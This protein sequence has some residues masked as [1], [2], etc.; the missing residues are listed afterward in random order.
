MRKKTGEIFLKSPELGAIYRTLTLPWVNQRIAIIRG[1]TMLLDPRYD[2]LKFT[3]LY[4]LYETFQF[5]L[6]NSTQ[7]PDIRGQMTVVL[8]LK[9]SPTGYQYTYLRLQIIEKT[10]V[11][12]GRL[13]QMRFSEIFEDPIEELTWYQVRIGIMRRKIFVYLEVPWKMQQM[14][15]VDLPEMPVI[16][17]HHM[18]TSFGGNT[19]NGAIKHYSVNGFTFDFST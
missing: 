2:Y 15:S 18:A 16:V 17:Y 8:Y 4:S 13:K 9:Y 5:R 14:V 1:G 10:L 6:E 12:D 7:R 19:F 11:L 3:N